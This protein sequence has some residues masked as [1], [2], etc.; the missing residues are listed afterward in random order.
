MS[1]ILGFSEEKDEKIWGKI[2]SYTAK[3]SK[4]VCLSTSLARKRV[5]F[6]MEIFGTARGNR[7]S[8]TLD[9]G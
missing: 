3:D 4:K 5:N 9:A 8:Q 6:P 2:L 7:E 1:V